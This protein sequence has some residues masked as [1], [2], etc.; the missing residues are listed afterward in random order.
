MWLILACGSRPTTREPLPMAVAKHSPRGRRSWAADLRARNQRPRAERDLAR[1]SGPGLSH[2]GPAFLGLL[3]SRPDPVRTGPSR[4]T[5]PTCAREEEDE[6]RGSGSERRAMPAR[7]RWRRGRD[8]NPRYA[9]DVH[10]LSKRAPSAARSPLRPWTGRWRRERDLNPRCPFRHTG[11]RNRRVQ[12]LRHL[13][14]APS[15][16]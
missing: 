5:E 4:Q 3:R 15:P 7:G 16:S 10:T 8:S 6:W 11:F 2:T 1:A 9:C 14:A 13:S 12:P